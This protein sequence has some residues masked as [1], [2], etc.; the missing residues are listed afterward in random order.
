MSMVQQAMP[1]TVTEDLL[2]SK[3]VGESYSRMGIKTTICVLTMAN[4]FEVVGTS[5]CVDPTNFNYDLGKKLA[6]ENAFNK[7]Y[8]LESYQMHTALRG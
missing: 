3:I 7:I 6:Y 4:G 5:A 2:K 1:S 8:E